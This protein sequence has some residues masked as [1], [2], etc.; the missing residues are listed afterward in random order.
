MKSAAVAVMFVVAELAGVLVYQWIKEPVKRAIMACLGFG[1][2]VAIVGFDILPDATRDY[3]LGYWLCGAGFAVMMA[4]GF[5][6]RRAGEYSAVAGLAFHNLAEGVMIS[7]AFASLSPA[8]V[9]G[10]VLHKLPEGML[11]ASLLRSTQEKSR[12]AVAGLVSLLVVAGVAL[13]IPEH[14]TRP[15]MAFSAGV[16]LFVAG[17]S[18]VAALAQGA[19]SAGRSISTASNEGSA[20]LAKLVPAALSGA[21]IGW[22]S[23]FLA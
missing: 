13:P 22:V 5:A 21:M 7:S 16:I 3:A 17:R 14:V 19:T 15:V 9:V 6:A 4:V 10:A 8:L 18:L 12:F 23:C 2:A 11:V 20:G 1:F